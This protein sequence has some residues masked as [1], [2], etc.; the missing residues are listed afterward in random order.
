MYR[1]SLRPLLSLALLAIPIALARPAAPG[2]PDTATHLDR[3]RSAPLFEGPTIGFA[4]VS[5]RFRAAYEALLGASEVAP[6]LELARARGAAAR[7][8]GV[9]GLV[10]L[11]GR[12]GEGSDALRGRAIDA[13]VALLEDERPVE[14][15]TS[16]QHGDSIVAVEAFGALG[17]ILT[18]VELDA[19]AA[20]LLREA[21]KSDAT[22]LRAHLAIERARHRPTMAFLGYL[23]EEIRDPAGGA[24]LL[25]SAPPDDARLRAARERT[26]RDALASRPEEI[27][28]A[29]VGAAL[30]LGATSFLETLLDMAR[31]TDEVA[32]RAL[33]ASATGV[34]ELLGS[35]AEGATLRAREALAIIRRD[36][37]VDSPRPDAAAMALVT[38]ARALDAEPAVG[39]VSTR[40][41]VLD[42]LESALALE[43]TSQPDMARALARLDRD[44]SRALAV[45][46]SR[47]ETLDPRALL[48]LVDAAGAHFASRARLED[49][50]LA[51]LRDEGS[52]WRAR[53]YAARGLGELRC[54]RAVPLLV[55]LA[56]RPGRLGREAARACARI[57]DGQDAS[58]SAKNGAG[59]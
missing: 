30:E 18:P 13:I 26:V 36:L 40:R 41:E 25:D 52:H 12:S 17:R 37:R 28:L 2:D 58:R 49:H 51:V 29:A 24:A 10:T 16:C 6:F 32:E 21:V 27:R 56:E 45:L 20:G 55:E 35:R 42:A 4:A 34:G 54:A 15:F 48:A 50:L 5:S 31:G 9:E 23:L 33:A 11:V 57:T 38:L 8:Y 43:A 59:R 39:D 46:E 7:V 14:V 3:L 44:G 19:V 53:L 22:S 1:T 47:L